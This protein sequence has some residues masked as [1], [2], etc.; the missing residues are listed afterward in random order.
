MRET[1]DKLDHDCREAMAMAVAADSRLRRLLHGHSLVFSRE[2]QRAARQCLE[3]V[4]RIDAALA[5]AR[6]MGV[7][8]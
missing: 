4:D 6:E 8:P 3:A 7:R 2:A 5:R 1:I